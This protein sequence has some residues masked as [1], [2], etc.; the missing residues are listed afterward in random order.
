M[1]HYT[2]EKSKGMSDFVHILMNERSQL[3]K[4]T[5]VLMAALKDILSKILLQCPLLDSICL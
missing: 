4:I 3:N 1:F 5:K 2:I